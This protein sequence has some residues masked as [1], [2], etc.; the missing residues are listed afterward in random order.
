MSLP[1]LH[2]RVAN[3]PSDQDLSLGTAVK[4]ETWGTLVSACFRIARSGSFD[5][6]RAL[7]MTIQKQMQ[8]VLKISWLGFRAFPP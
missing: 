7:R 4:I 2:S 8:I 6:P 1:S 3:H 5:L